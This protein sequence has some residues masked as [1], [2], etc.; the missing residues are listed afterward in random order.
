[1]R[2]LLLVAALL[3]AVLR[4]PVSEVRKRR[5]V[6]SDRR[7]IVRHVRLPCGTKL[8]NVADFDTLNDFPPILR[9][10]KIRMNSI[11]IKNPYWDLWFW[12]YRLGAEAELQHRSTTLNKVHR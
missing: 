2:L 10:S 11:K 7:N 4:R 9:E 1:M 12:S 6:T 5:G 8:P 3:S